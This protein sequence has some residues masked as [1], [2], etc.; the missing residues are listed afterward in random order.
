M[1][2]GA[3]TEIEQIKGERAGDPEPSKE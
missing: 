2:K 3:N 1:T